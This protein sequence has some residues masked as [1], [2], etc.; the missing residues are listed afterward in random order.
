V[1]STGVAAPG[2]QWGPGRHLD[3]AEDGAAEAPPCPAYEGCRTE[4]RA[5]GGQCLPRAASVAYAPAIASG[6]TSLVPSVNDGTRCRGRPSARRTPIAS[7]SAAGAEMPVRS[8]SCMYQVL[9]LSQVAC[10]IVKT[11][12]SESA[13][14]ATG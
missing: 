4:T 5:C 7:A 11:P 3:V 6:V 13:A 1:S 10:S 8:C 2:R 9:T 12:D 14:F